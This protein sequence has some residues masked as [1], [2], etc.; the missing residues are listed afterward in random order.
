MQIPAGVQCRGGQL[1]RGGISGYRGVGMRLVFQWLCLVAG[2][3]VCVAA[4]EPVVKP[5][6][7]M[8]Q[9]HTVDFHGKILQDP[10]F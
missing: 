7:A 10:Y 2:A 1:L 3:G 6:V 8:Q 5:P 9:P 4:D